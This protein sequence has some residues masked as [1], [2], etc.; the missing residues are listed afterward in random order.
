MYIFAF[1]HH[2][3]PN[4]KKK[5]KH[6]D[7][8]EPKTMDS[9]VKR[10]S[11]YCSASASA[12]SSS[13]PFL[14]LGK[15]SSGKTT[16]L[17]RLVDIRQ[18][19]AA[20]FLREKHFRRTTLQ[21]FVRCKLTAGCTVFLVD[22][23]D[24]W[25]SS[26]KVATSFIDL[27]KKW[28]QLRIVCTAKIGFFVTGYQV[29]YLN[30]AFSTE[31]NR[32]RDR[33][34]TTL[35]QRI[36]SKNLDEAISLVSVHAN[37]M[38]EDDDREEPD[39]HVIDKLSRHC[40]FISILSVQQHHTSTELAKTAGALLR[41]VTFPRFVAK[42]TRAPFRSALTAAEPSFCTTL[43]ALEPRTRPIR[44]ESDAYFRVKLLLDT[45]AT[46]EN[47]LTFQMK[48]KVQLARNAEQRLLL[49]SKN[50]TMVEL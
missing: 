47:R 22:D 44:N 43:A 9:I 12:S 26:K 11:A 24:V 10:A 41:N 46:L 13:R 45:E 33:E 21:T 15:T 2:F 28:P 8:I 23:I 36:N 20:V 3:L 18:R 4:L 50:I 16:M 14:I 30:R 31:S 27:C 48:K 39:K 34:M 35:R 42:P 1:C 32:A 25:K 40:D 17:R 5:Q 49:Q 7:I 29:L 19:R 38:D 37:L 6:N